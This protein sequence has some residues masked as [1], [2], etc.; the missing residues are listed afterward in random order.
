M[1]ISTQSAEAQCWFDRGMAWSYN[2]S[3]IEARRC[4]EKVIEHDPDSPMGY[5]GV[6]YAVGPY[7]NLK[8]ESYSPQGL[9]KGLADAYNFTQQ[10]KAKASN[11]SELEQMLVGA[12]VDRYPTSTPPDDAVQEE[13]FAEWDTAYFEAMRDVYAAYPDHNDVCALTAEALVLPDSWL[14]WDLENEV[15]A[16]GTHTAE[17]LAIL[18][19]ALERI[20][21]SGET[22][23]PGVLHFLI[24][25]L[26][27]SPEPERALEASD[28]LINLVPDGAHLIHMPSH[29]YVLCGLYQKSLEANQAADIADTKYIDHDP[30]IS[31]YTIYQLHNLH[32]QVY[33]AM[34]LGQYEP[35][36]KVAERM[37]TL[38]PIGA[39]SGDHKFLVHYLEGY[40]GMKVH[41]LIRFGK[42]DEIIQHPLPPDPELYCVTNALWQYA[43]G[44]AYAA[45]G[46]VPNAILQQQR[47]EEAL[48]IVGPERKV[49]NNLC[50]D[51][52]K[53]GEKMLAGEL[54]YRRENYEL[55]FD[56]LRECV[57][58]YDGLNYTEPWSWMQPP[59]HA[60]GALLME[61]GHV[62]E[63]AAVYRADL[64]LDDTLVRPSQHVD[65]VWALHGYVECLEAQGDQAEAAVYRKKLKEAQ[66]VAVVE[67]SSSCFCRTTHAQQVEYPKG[68]S[69]CC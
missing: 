44:V 37:E 5:W 39:L 8:W 49:F 7:Y 42:W 69:S 10:A 43:K 54:E 30:E 20:K 36:L 19:K 52:L 14:L 58:L 50:M 26:E 32:F 33:S 24:H 47:F 22:H 65:N 13:A 25:I 12:F 18:E 6:A 17:A 57:D 60:L 2:F 63:A 51:T 40:V 34:F 56:L 61:Q 64:G 11:G 28:I 31:I 35:A 27:M 9:I 15:P 3:H 21:A 55:A 4:F 45:R 16:E 1:P 66:K 48:K 62:D 23:H 46:D 67:V 53:V 68:T 41:V 29:I 59:R 38:V